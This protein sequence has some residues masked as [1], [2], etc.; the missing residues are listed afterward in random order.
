MHLFKYLCIYFVRNTVPI[1]AHNLQVIDIEKGD[2]MRDKLKK[3]IEGGVIGLLMVL[4]GCY[5]VDTTPPEAP[6]GLTS[7]TGDEAVYLY[8]NENT[9]PDLTGYRLYRNDAPSGYFVL[10]ADIKE[11]CYVDRDVENGITYFYAVSAYDDDGNESELSEE[12]CFDTPRPEGFNMKIYE[13]DYLPDFSG[14]SFED[15]RPCKYNSMYTDIYY[16]LLGGITYII[17]T[18]G[19]LIQDMGSYYMDDISYA[20]IDGWDTLGV[21]PA[22]DGHVYVVWT[23]DNHFAKFRIKAVGNTYVVF[24]WAYQ[25][26]EGNRELV[27]KSLKY[28]RKEVLHD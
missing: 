27:P 25:I 15:A 14:Y 16:D 11:P 23:R 13:K 24:D 20:P 17:A 19:T 22:I 10:I 6:T 2:K 9:E 5:E 21:V 1:L 4:S 3:M 28:M 7:I 8:W 18:T 26:A 12:D